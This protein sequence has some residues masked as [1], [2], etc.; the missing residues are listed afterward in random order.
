MRSANDRALINM[1]RWWEDRVVDR[2]IFRGLPDRAEV[3]FN[4]YA[5]PSA[6]ENLDIHI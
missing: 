4:L 3:Y 6:C 5:G 2:A 1:L